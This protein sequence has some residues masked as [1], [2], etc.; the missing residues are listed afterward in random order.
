MMSQALGPVKR[1]D[2]AFLAL[3]P[4]QT[5][6]HTGSVCWVCLAWED[7]LHLAGLGLLASS[8][9]LQGHHSLLW[10]ELHPASELQRL[11]IGSSQSLSHGNLSWSIG[12]KLWSSETWGRT[13]GSMAESSQKDQCPSLEQSPRWCSSHHTPTPS[14]SPSSA[15]PICLKNS[16]PLSN[17]LHCLKGF[18]IQPSSNSSYPN[19]GKVLLLDCSEPLLPPVVGHVPLG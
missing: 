7:S 3:V 1:E 11:S 12:R 14:H 2:S 8:V 16:S 6:Q 19:E 15:V 10:L 9:Q 17:T 13:M 5:T 4:S 18:K